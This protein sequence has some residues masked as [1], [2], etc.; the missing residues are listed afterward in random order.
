MALQMTR[1]EYKNRYGVAPVAPASSSLDTTPAPRR[2]TREEYNAEFN[3]KKPRLSTPELT[4]GRSDLKDPEGLP[5]LK[6]MVDERQAVSERNIKRYVE[7]PSLKTAP[8]FLYREFANILGTGVDV[9]TKGIEKVPIVGD[10]QKLIMD[11][12]GKVIEGTG[13]AVGS[14]PAVQEAVAKMSDEDFQ[15][16]HSNLTVYQNIFHI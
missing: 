3:T 15:K 11:I 12:F 9:V 14:I 16:L 7:N 13:E 8:G 4:L 2:M 1:E 5:P 10:A 6:E